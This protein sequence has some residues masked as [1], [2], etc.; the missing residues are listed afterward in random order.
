MDASIYRMRPCDV[1]TVC[2]LALLALGVVMVQSASTTLNACITARPGVD[3]RPRPDG[4]PA[5]P[6]GLM[7]VADAAR[8]RAFLDARLRLRR[9]Q[10]QNM[11][12]RHCQRSVHADPDGGQTSLH[13]RGRSRPAPA[14]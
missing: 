10:L 12:V 5:A 9:H 1:L 13:L 11:P 14:R 8:N 6:A 3:P 7:A 2:V 4:G